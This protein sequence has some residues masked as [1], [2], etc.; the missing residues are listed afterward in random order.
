MLINSA[1]VVC[2]LF[3]GYGLFLGAWRRCL[4]CLAI[5]GLLGWCC[6]C[7]LGL[8]GLLFAFAQVLRIM[9][10][11]V[12]MLM[13]CSAVGFCTCLAA[14]VVLF[15]CLV[16]IVRFALIMLWFGGYCLLLVALMV[17]G[18]WLAVAGGLCCWLIVGY[19]SCFAFTFVVR[20]VAFL[21]VCRL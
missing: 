10:G 15:S 11:W 2:C 12:C 1:V 6:V 18:L 17:F 20:S 21:V 7:L 5:V 13:H 3:I 4:W 8:I 9:V 19:V 14:C 16:F